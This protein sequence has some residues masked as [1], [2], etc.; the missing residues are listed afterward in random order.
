MKLVCDK[1]KS[2]NLFVEIQG[3]RKGLYCGECGTWQKWI[4]KQELQICKFNNIP[5]KEVKNE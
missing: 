2:S 3:S 4:N 5:I 1:C